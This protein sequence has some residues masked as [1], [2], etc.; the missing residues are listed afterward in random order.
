VWLFGYGGVWLGECVA[1][2]LWWGVVGGSL[3][4]LGNGG[5][6]LRKCVARYE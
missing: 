2:W 1:V 6:W 5:V 4:L 3:W